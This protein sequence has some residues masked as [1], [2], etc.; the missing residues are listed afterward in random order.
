M[1]P[2]KLIQIDN[3]IDISLN[4]QLGPETAITKTVKC[5]LLPNLNNNTYTSKK[6]NINEG[7]IVF[8]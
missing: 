5:K 1:D 8:Y 7:E 6:A 2:E 4:A 3:S